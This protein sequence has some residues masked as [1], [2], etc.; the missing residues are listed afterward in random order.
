M[1]R[2]AG[3]W[4]REQ[5]DVQHAKQ[6]RDS[7]HGLCEDTQ[8]Y[9]TL[10]TST[11]AKVQSIATT[12]RETL[13]CHRREGGVE[14]DFCCK[15]RLFTWERLLMQDQSE[16]QEL[17]TQLQTPLNCKHTP[18]VPLR[19]ASLQRC[20]DNVDLD[21]VAT[22]SG[23]RS[24]GE[25][26]EDSSRCGSYASTCITRKSPEAPLALRVDRGMGAGS[27][28]STQSREAEFS[29]GE[30]DCSTRHA[31]RSASGKSDSTDS[32]LWKRRSLGAETLKG[33][34]PSMAAF[35]TSARDRGSNRRPMREDEKEPRA[36]SPARDRDKRDTSKWGWATW[37]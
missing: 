8:C 17:N 7:G 36:V 21:H 13:G 9:I 15:S 28:A 6:D 16:D 32:A 4:K 34:F 37:F 19:N 35:S 27:S 12:D 29:H 22:L 20:R 1:S 14:V 30:P 24:Q 18:V 11:S 25:I 26:R 2:L 31:Q 5:R 3:N 23:S 33:L 10:V